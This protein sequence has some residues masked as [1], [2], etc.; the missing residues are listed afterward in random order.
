MIIT[1]T[2]LRVG[3]VGGGTDLPDFYREH[4]GRVLNAAIDKYVY[5]VVKQRFD[6]D[7]YVNY[8]SKEVVSRVEDLQH[9]LVREAM[10][11]T[12]VR[13]G[14]EITT[15]A[16]I[17][18]AGSGLGSSSAVTVGLLHALFAYKG[19]QVTAEEL[20]D[21]ACAIE[22]DRCRKPIGKQ[23]QYAAAYGGI[24]DLHF[25]PG[26]RVVV[27]QLDLASPVRRQVQDEL[28]LFYTGTTRKADNILGEQKANIGDRITQLVQL[29]ELAAEASAGL[30]E[31]DVDALG[32]ALNKSWAAKRELASGVSNSQIDEA[33]ESA[34]AGGATGAKVTGAGGGGFLLVVCPL[35]RQRAVRER[36][37]A[38]KELPIKIDPFG[39]RVVLNVHRD[40][41]S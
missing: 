33:V 36:L 13:G 21:R 10:H 31:G 4:G 11:M 41:W 15:L 19:R 40:I 6:D 9:E 38:M 7:V 2:P 32:V 30:R 35:E 22:I 17:P 37:A 25:G 24:C 23:D 14:V 28:L 20:A 8:S 29:R 39:S 12:G 34:L 26:D 5:V 1:Q 3:L 16:D 18:S 27:D